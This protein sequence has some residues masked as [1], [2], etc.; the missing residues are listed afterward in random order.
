LIER[1]YRDYLYPAAD[2]PPRTTLAATIASGT[3]TVQFTDGLLT[4]EEEALLGAGT[5]I[6]ID[7]ELMLVTAINT[8]THTLT[9]IRNQ[10]G[11]TA[12]AHTIGAGLFVA[13]VYPRQVLFDAVADNVVRL[14]P[15]LWSVETDEITTASAPVEVESDAVEIV[16][17]MYPDTSSISGSTR[18][19]HG[20]AELLTDF[21]YV[22]STVAIQFHE[23]VPT[24]RTGYLTYK[25]R[26]LRPTKEDDDL[27]TDF[28]VD[29]SWDRIIVVGA[30]LDAI[31]AR[32]IDI[33]TQNFITETAAAEAFPV[34]SGEKIRNALIRYY[35]YLLA[36]AKRSLQ[37][38]YP[39]GMEY[40]DTGTYG[41]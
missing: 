20:A 41:V 2:R 10:E 33:A 15:S 31:N 32:D 28:G 16:K 12:V 34:G 29:R 24:G 9:V 30:T 35:E 17:F 25:R 13:P 36:Q 11:T 23:S 37:H 19:M 26:F 27:S 8:T 38:R 14:Y 7:R 39:L 6:E 21:S 1:A 5:L 18:W 4:P 40:T 3:T 22:T